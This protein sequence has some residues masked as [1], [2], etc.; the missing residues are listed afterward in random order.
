M[1]TDGLMRVWLVVVVC[2]VWCGAAAGETPLERRVAEIAEQVTAGAGEA[3]TYDA[4]FLRA[5]PMGQI[6]GLYGQMRSQA[7]AVVG[8]EASGAV[9]ATAGRF[10]F[11]FA[12]GVESDVTV[13]LQPGAP[14]RVV[15]LF[16]EPMRASGG[17]IEETVAGLAALPGRV[18]VR[19]AEVVDGGELAVV[20]ELNADE[21]LA[22]GSTFK[23]YI[24]A[25]LVEG[26]V[27]WARVVELDEAARSLPSG[28][29]QD[30]PVGSPATLHT[31]ASLMISISDNTATDTLLAEVGAERVEGLLEALGNEHAGRNRPCLSTLEL[32]KL[33][34]NKAVEARYAAADE[35]GR[36]AL[37]DGPVSVMSRDAVDPAV[38]AGGPGAIEEAEW[39]ASAA[40]LCRLMAWFAERGDE[41]ALGV[42]SINPGLPIADRF[43]RVAFKGGSEPGVLNLTLLVERKDG[44][45]F[46]V[47]AGWNN[48][49]AALEDGALLE[50]MQSVLVGVAEL[51]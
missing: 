47:S 6:N 9:S 32:F 15:G 7:G 30:W 18:S 27:D 29:M 4:S 51:E 2:A 42:M 14:H 35:A 11:R 5:V 22:I 46:A 26:G 28:M 3:D 8:Y 39:F 40:D 12:N 21:A 48:P 24:L 1:A 38:F 50:A 34:S 41:T 10:V 44:R 49:D 31:L 33:R 17:S 19:V 13:T 23:L 20:A 45:V 43:A 25:A 37:L 36:R 16:F